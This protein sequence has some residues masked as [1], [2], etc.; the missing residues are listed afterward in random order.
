MKWETEKG[1]E[2]G[3]GPQDGIQTWDVCSATAVYVSA[4]PTRL[5]VPTFIYSLIH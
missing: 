5:S 1:V 3:K 2:I 4:L